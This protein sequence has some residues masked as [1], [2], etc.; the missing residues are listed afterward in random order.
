[1]C[2]SMVDIQFATAENRRRKKIERRRN[3]MAEIENIMS[4]SATQG[5]HNNYFPLTLQT[6]TNASMMSIW[7]KEKPIVKV[8]HHAQYLACLLPS[9]LITEGRRSSCVPTVCIVACPSPTLSTLPLICSTSP[10]YHLSIFASA[11]LDFSSNQVYLPVF[12]CIGLW[13]WPHDQNTEAYN[14]SLLLYSWQQSFLW[15]YF[16][17]HRCISPMCRPA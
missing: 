8:N 11:C 13:L 5:G 4:A 10:W 17:Q 16:L 1:M 7:G 6:I 12:R 14:T 15:L 9:F 3:H 2:G